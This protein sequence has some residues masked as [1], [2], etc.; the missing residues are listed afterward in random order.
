MPHQI[1][2]TSQR[3][4]A[5][6]HH[7][8]WVSASAGSGKTKV[9]TDRI[10]NLLLEGCSP[11]RI[12]CLTFTKAAAAEMAS[13]IR[14]RLGEWAILPEQEL[15]KTLETLQNAA[16]SSEKILRARMLFG[17]TLDT[18][19][20]L[21][22]QTIHSFCQSLLKRFPLE[23][24]LSP[25]FRVTDDTEHKNLI[26][27]AFYEAM[28]DSQLQKLAIHFAEFSFDE[29]NTFIL[30]KR[31]SFKDLNSKEINRALETE[32]LT[33]KIL[34]D[35]LLQ[36]IPEEQLRQALPAF[37]QGSPTDEKRGEDLAHFLAFS[38]QNRHAKH[39]NYLS[40]FLTQEGEKR[41]RLLTQKLS[42]SFPALG[43]V[44]EKEAT[45]LE[46]WTN[47]WNALEISSLSKAFLR[48]GLSFLQK[49]EDLKRA[50]SLLD[51]E[52]LILKTVSLLKD[53]G[54]HW[55]LY[56]LDGGLDHILVD[57]AQDTS[58]A[59]WQVIREIA[60]EFYAGSAADPRNRTL[61]VVGDDKQSIYSFQGADP[62]VFTQ[63]QKD[64]KRF[65]Q[66]SSKDWQD[67]QLNVSFRSTPEILRAVDAVFAG[68]PL[69]SL[70]L[71][72]LPFRKDAPGHVEIWPLVKKEKEDPLESWQPP[73]LSHS[74]KD[75]PPKQLAYLMA[76]TIQGWLGGKGPLSRPVKPGDILILVRRR[77]GF[78]DELIRALKTYHVPVAGIDRL[79]LLEGLGI[80]DL[81]KIGEF[82]LLPE[83]DLTLATVLKGPL[84]NFSEEDLFTLAHG[85]GETSLWQR[86][87]KNE[88]FQNTTS[89][90][91]DLLSRSESMTPFAFYSHILGSLGGRKKWQASLGPEV[92]D[93]LDEFLNLCLTFQGEKTPTLQGFIK[94]ISEEEIELKRDLD[95]SDLVRIMTVHGSKG[96]QA[97]IVFLPDTTQTPTELPPFEFHGEA[98][99]WLP[100]SAKDVPLTKILKQ[101]L[102][103]KQMEEYNRLL[104]VA[105]T[106]AEDALYV[107]GW[108]SSSQE[109]W[110]TQV[111]QGLQRVGEE[112]DFLPL[113]EKGLRL[114]N[115]QEMVSVSDER[116]QIP[117]FLLPQWLLTPP[118][119][120]STPK[121]L[122]PSESAEKEI[123]GDSPFGEFGTQRGIL[124]HR[125][126][127]FLP[128][129]KEPE[130]ERKAFQYLNNEDVP[131]DLI[132]GMIASA[133]KIFQAYP[134][135]FGSPSYAEVPIIGY[136]SESLLS[137]Q[138]DRLI[139]NED[140]VLIVD[141]KTHTHVPQN[142]T[143]IPNTYVRQMALYRHALTHIYPEKTILCGLLWTELPRLD[144]LPEALLEKHLLP[145][146]PS[147]PGGDLENRVS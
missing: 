71:Q 75:A 89:F 144:L 33:E 6:P 13:R 35:R 77:T 137:G 27:K 88:R 105:L 37:Q 24:G 81:L 129:V 133:Q 10:L 17:I 65:A 12:L 132:P 94:W 55:V 51:Y 97:P 84:F 102:R 127:E 139:I 30:Q 100:P 32:G 120:E 92:L 79:W 68:S 107:C 31:D 46:N 22:I 142:I 74:Q 110:Y 99:L 59:Q 103:A 14:I 83:D 3:L 119:L 67:I 49:Y 50:E 61:F 140:H 141:Y 134:D 118:P 7:S 135:L 114:S 70:P 19:G 108:E 20:G 21:K 62:A 8:A 147:L 124:I 42:H 128:L 121:L 69:S 34:M 36:G 90:L 56:K 101:S 64:L 9:L 45:R 104:Y 48:Y 87:L 23:A 38:Y 96:L 125:L 41:A 116:P 115:L 91:K 113:N 26:K 80:Q 72:H 123:W 106:R 28:E 93:S 131:K 66:N 73:L 63:M 138:I 44:L 60:E 109:N 85:R 136:M 143:D 11:E 29:F 78:V 39:E 122:R 53:P 25:F 43:E 98:F 112:F 117:P 58:P 2:A 95:Q 4:A 1:A 57:E 146:Q 54:C 76:K 15:Q 126:L 86:L 130:R 18:P 47:Q 82:L 52:D 145:L 111:S 16:P 40:I 5:H